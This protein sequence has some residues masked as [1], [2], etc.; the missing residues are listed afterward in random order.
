MAHA[1]GCRQRRVRPAATGERPTD[2]LSEGAR[3]SAVSVLVGGSFTCRA[4]FAPRIHSLS[5]SLFPYLV[6]LDT[7]AVVT[8]GTELGARSARLLLLRRGRLAAFD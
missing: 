8:T 3:P 4:T 2:D 7:V 6:R 1:G 5:L